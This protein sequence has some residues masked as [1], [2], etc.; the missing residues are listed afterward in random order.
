[1]MEAMRVRLLELQNPDGGWGATTQRPSNTEATA[2]AAL[3]LADQTAERNA[4]LT[5]LTNRQRPDG[6]WPWTD[7]LDL[8]SWSTSLAMLALAGAQTAP[9]AVNRGARW[10]LGQTGPGVPW[11]SRIMAFLRRSGPPPVELDYSVE[12]WA[13]APGTFSWVEPT[14]WALLAL[15]AAYPGRRPRG[16]ENRIREGEAMILDRACPGGGWNYGNRRVLG[17]DLEPYPDTTALALL[18]LQGRSDRKVEEGMSALQRMTDDG[19]SGLALALAALC[20]QAHGLDASSLCQRVG[21]RF[22]ETGLMDETRSIALATI[23]IAGKDAFR[24]PAHV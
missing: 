2:L 7:E 19:A 16:V 22:A 10:L 24:R 6:C 1:M 11:R 12:G 21:Q 9:D 23:A 15:G 4:G 3:A 20:W 14:T 17:V 8:P 18:A 5:W 13:W